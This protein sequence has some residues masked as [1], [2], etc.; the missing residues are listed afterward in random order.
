MMARR[1]LTASI[2]LPVLIFIVWLGGLWFA[3]LIAV[4][5][6]TGAWELCRLATAAEKRPLMPVAVLL[7]IVLSI[8]YHF[9]SAPR[10]PENMEFVAMIPAMAAILSA[11]ALL[12]VRSL[13]GLQGRLF[14]T[15]CIVL[16]IGGTLFHAPILRDFELFPNELSLGIRWTLFLLGVTFAADTAAYFTDRAIGSRRFCSNMTWRGAAGGILAAVVCGVFLSSA[17]DLSAPA[18]TAAVASIILAI[19]GHVG[20]KFII[21][22]KRTA[23]VEYTG[24]LLPGYGGILDRM[25]SLM[26]SL[27]ILYHLVAL[28]SGSTA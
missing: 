7:A 25:G 23:G 16:V 1:I 28:A 17:L 22:M 6:G 4:A 18:P 13:R 24:R 20:A 21:R 15:L 8:S 3:A 27:V 11:I 2:A 5:A 10:H 19:I 12:R 9:I 26:W 14:V